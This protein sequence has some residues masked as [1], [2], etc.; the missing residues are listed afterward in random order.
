ML[1]IHKVYLLKVNLECNDNLL[2]LSRAR[3]TSENV[4]I[5]TS[6]DETYLFCCCFFTEKK[7]AKIPN[8]EVLT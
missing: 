1:L 8:G 4:D 7:E 2:V 3:S 6:R 5:F